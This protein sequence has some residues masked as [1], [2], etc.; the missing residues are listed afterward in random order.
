[1]SKKPFNFYP[2]YLERTLKNM[3]NCKFKEYFFLVTHEHKMKRQP[4]HASVSKFD[5]K[6][7]ATFNVGKFLSAEDGIKKLKVLENSNEI[8]VLNCELHIDSKYLS[9]SDKSS[10]VIYFYFLFFICSK[11]NFSTAFI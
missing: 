6:H 7:L 11:N 5:V 4:V 10:K 9:I 3:E 2:K 8:H 1:M